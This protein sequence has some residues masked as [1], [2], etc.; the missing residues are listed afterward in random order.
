MIWRRI[1]WGQGA[2]LRPDLCENGAMGLCLYSDL[3]ADS[4]EH[5]LPA[6]FGEFE[7]APEL[8]NRVCMKCNNTT[9]GKLDEQLARCGP[10]GFLRKFFGVQGRRSHDKVNPFERGSAGGQRL[11]VRAWD[12]K[13]GVEVALEFENGSPRNM[14]EL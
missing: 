2:A 10:E 7:N 14:R 5:T 11:D 1:C 8:L 4:L 13:R 9:L 3:P 6:A 12:D